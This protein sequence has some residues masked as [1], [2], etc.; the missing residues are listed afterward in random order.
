MGFSWSVWDE[1]GQNEYT[2]LPARR[3]ASSFSFLAFHSRH[4]ASLFPQT[5]AEA[6]SMERQI[7][8]KTGIVVS[9]ALKGPS[10]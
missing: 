8:D 7:G 5:N 2:R 1:G 9:T 4:T 6:I 10:K 3:M